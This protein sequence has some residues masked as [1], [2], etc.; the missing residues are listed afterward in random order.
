MAS[1]TVK[2]A[3]GETPPDRIRAQILFKPFCEWNAYQPQG[4]EENG[5][6]RHGSIRR[7]H[8]TKDHHR[9]AEKEKRP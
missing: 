7:A 4:D 8:N 2:S 6:R 1:V 5:E 9:Y 3:D